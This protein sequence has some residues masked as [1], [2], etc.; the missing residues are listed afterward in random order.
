MTF[1]NLAER[2]PM[3]GAVRTTCPYCGVGCGILATPNANRSAAGGSGADSPVISGDPRHPAN[4]GRLCSK[5]SALGET[6]GLDGR[7][8]RPRILGRDTG[9]S[10]ALHYVAAGFNRIIE[11]HGADA[12]AFYVSGQLSTEDYYVANKLMKGYIGSANIDTNSRLCMSSAVAAHKRAFGEDV[13]P[14]SY[15]DLELADLIVLVGSNTAWCHPVVYQRIVAAKARRPE[16]KIVV[17]DPRATATCDAADLHLPVKAGTDVWL[18]NG[19]LDYLHQHGVENRAFIDAHT[20]DAQRALT[21]AQNTAGGTGAVA[22]LCGLELS[23]LEEFYRLFARTQRVVTVFSQGVNQ[24]SSGTD[25]AN[26]IINCHLLTGRIGRPGAGPFSITG[27]PNAMGGREVGGLATV[28][29]AHL[30]LENPEHRR[31]VQDFW[32][33]PRIAERPGLKAVDLFEALHAGTVKAV[34]IAGTNPVVSLPNADRARAA[35]RRCEFVV[36]SDC[37]ADTDTTRLAHV[38]LPATAWGEKDGTVTN[39]E[40]CISR[41][42][43]F[44]P[45]P[46]AAQPDWWIFAQAAKHMGFTDGFDYASAHDV[47]V[48][49]ARLSA[50]GNGGRRAFDIG[51]LASLDAAGYAAL[52]PTRWPARAGEEPS[53]HGRLFADGRFFHTDG[54][55][56]FIAIT[57][58]PPAHALDEEYPLVLNTGRSRDQWH[59]MTRSGKSARLMTHAPEPYVDM[60]PQDALLSGVRVGEFVR[61]TTRWGSLVARLRTSGE[62]PRRMIFV[63]IH[64]SDVNSADARV[65]SLVN[66]AVDPLSGEPEFKHTPVRVDSFVVA[67]QGFALHRQALTLKGAAWWS[68]TRGEDFLRYEM[69]GRRVFGDWSPWARGLLQVPPDADWLEYVD[70]ST[71]VYRA[72][73]LVNERIEG[74]VFISPRPDLPPRGWVSSLFAK[75]A[76]DARDRAGLLMGQPADATADAGPV[77]CSCF[78]VGRNTICSAIRDFGLSSSEQVGQRLRAGTNCGSCLPEIKAILNE[79]SATLEA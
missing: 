16:V 48:E 1:A 39:S 8:L 69:A 14:V 76:L 60:H 77:V 65:G 63:P 72:A 36:V 40:R 43:S 70:R 68:V 67:W 34:W 23:A 29:A 25:K 74:C 44:L 42:R 35:L 38:L 51:A 27:Q 64:W 55:A 10:E 57:P 66:P 12:V 61:V 22:R 6:L 9:W 7:L 13:V 18:F 50:Q 26:S 78:G 59:T 3:S 2:P 21:V 19:L 20:A 47:F 17:I 24:S 11:Q 58:C 30:E 54:R 52:A 37:V 53:A 62:M 45:A 28:L 49:H 75:P 79:H 32:R 73:Y 56:R 15:E 46:G 4:Q 33:S 31:T 41:Q 71:G 5:G